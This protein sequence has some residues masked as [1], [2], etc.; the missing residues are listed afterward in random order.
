M[1]QPDHNTLW[2][3]YKAH[4]DPMRGLLRRTVQVAVKAGLVDLVLQAVD[5][6]KIA[7]NASRARVYDSD[8]LRGVLA[9]VEAAIADLEAANATGGDPPP[10]RLPEDLA[11]AEALRRRVSEAIARVEEDGPRYTNLTDPDAGLLSIRG[12]GFVAGYNAQAVAA[13]LKPPDEGGGGL[14]ITA[15]GLAAGPDDHLQL[16]PMIEASADNLGQGGAGVTL[17]DAGYHSGANLAACDAAGHQ[18]LM[19]SAQ[20]RKRRSPYHKA[21]FISRPE[22][23][24][25]LCPEGET[26]SSKDSFIHENGYALRRYQAPAAACRACPA[27][28]R[29]TTSGRG[30]SIRVSEY[31]PLLQRHNARMATSSAKERYRR[32]QVLIEPP[33]GIL[34]E[35][36]GARRFLL[37]GRCNVLSEWS[38][39]ATG[40]NLKS[41]HRM[42]VRRTPPCMD[43][44][45]QGRSRGRLRPSQP[46]V[47]SGALRTRC[48]PIRPRPRR[49]PPFPSPTSQ[50]TSPTNETG[51]RRDLAQ[52]TV[53]EDAPERLWRATLFDGLTT[54][55]LGKANQIREANDWRGRRL[56]R[57][58]IGK[59]VHELPLTV[60][61]GLVY[62][63]GRREG[64]GVD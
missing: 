63:G 18:V 20:D 44:T 15:V 5:G 8:G 64:A 25:Y 60:M 26:L 17:A 32:R 54:N 42:G 24:A 1:Q 58:A 6:T 27:F 35:G 38:L 55:Q 21:H 29:C 33:F 49:H 22:T 16:V 14:L 45:H 56:G 43:A 23:D 50:P 51:S 11:R 13:A 48:L 47:R 37:R 10:A 12:G 40:F 62:G 52:P 34:K 2:R 30:R 41:L 19:P 61:R 7:G 46:T 9:R 3:F 39:L 53:G 57:R 59:A 28:G 36:H 4:R 31:E